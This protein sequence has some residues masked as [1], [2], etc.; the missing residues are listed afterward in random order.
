MVDKLVDIVRRENKKHDNNFV[1]KT[2][3]PK[4]KLDQ[5]LPLIIVGGLIIILL[6]FAVVYSRGKAIA[7]EIIELS[8][9]G[10]FTL[11]S[12]KEQV[13]TADWNQALTSFKQSQSVFKEL[14]DKSRYF[15]GSVASPKLVAEAGEHLSK[16]GELMTNVVLNVSNLPE[17]VLEINL[18]NSDGPKESI[19]NELVAIQPDLIEVNENLKAALEKFQNVNSSLLPKETRQQ[20]TEAIAALE[21][22]TNQFDQLE[23]DLPA[24]LAL[25]GNDAVHRYLILVQNNYELRPTG[26]F[27]GNLIFVEVSEG[28]MTLFEKHDVYDY[29]GQLRNPEEVP[30]EYIG[31]VTELGIRDANYVPHFPTSAEKID[32][33]LQR[34]N[35]PSFDT[36]VAVDHKLLNDLLRH[37]GAINLEDYPDGE[38]TAENFSIVL[39][40]L[41]EANKLQNIN[42]KGILKGFVEDL[43]T[44][45]LANPDIT[46]LLRIININVQTKH[47]QLF[48][49]DNRIQSIFE[50]YGVAGTVSKDIA[51]DEDYLLITNSSIGGNKTDPYIQ[52]RIIHTTNIS[53]KA[54]VSNDLTI[55][56]F[57]SFTDREELYWQRLLRPFGVEELHDPT[58][59]VLGRGDNVSQVKVYVPFGSKLTS[60]SGID[61]NTIQT[62]NDSETLKTYFLFP[63]SVSPKQTTEVSI[64]YETP[65]KLNP[66][67]VTAYK[68]N[69]QKQSGTE[70][71]IFEKYYN[72]AEN[73]KPETYYPKDY[74]IDKEGD[75]SYEFTLN[76]DTKMAAIIRD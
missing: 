28:N 24:I 59:Y 33:L 32:K 72:I 18:T 12:A 71:V 34:A 58:R 16:A 4:T 27:I 14:K 2:S 70:N 49:K 47:I 3:K 26:G 53:A 45:I 6:T 37:T 57:H 48:S 41:I 61:L 74:N 39:T 30:P 52:E 42:D 55:R 69:L 40:Y 54:K 15:E 67:P 64:S 22:I 19:T 7:G 5:A 13:K 9:T 73:F 63:M 51:D 29:D 23:R 21:A 50:R 17:K 68:L 60:A 76:S 43:K 35:A 1:W 10:Y 38:I 75:Y 36:I 31:F 44:K 66:K 25:L 56:K 20:F 11:D 62:F 65:I 8:K 46:N